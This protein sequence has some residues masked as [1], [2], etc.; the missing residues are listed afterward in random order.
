ML[1]IV[2]ALGTLTPLYLYGGH[3]FNL[4]YHARNK[5][6]IIAFDSYHSEKMTM[7]TCKA[8]RLKKRCQ[9][10]GTTK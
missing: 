9:P 2:L 3:Y 7:I 8:L 4:C 5:E 1:L 10:M 6:T